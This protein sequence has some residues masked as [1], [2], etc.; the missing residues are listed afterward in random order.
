MSHSVRP[1]FGEYTSFAKAYPQ[2]REIRLE[3]EE[4][5]DMP[6]P[7]QCERHQVF[8]LHNLPSTIRCG[9]PRCRQGGFDITQR[10]YFLVEQHETL[11][12]WEMHCPGQEGSPKG[13]R[14]G[15]PCC[16]HA[17]LRAEL[18]YTDESKQ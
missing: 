10:I 12:S 5:G 16:N 8:G 9:N 13:R 1:L 11:D 3:V 18:E 7:Q 17:K 6:R 14:K 15:N 4:T 2:V